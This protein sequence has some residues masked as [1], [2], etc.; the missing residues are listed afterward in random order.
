MFFFAHLFYKLTNHNFPFLGS[1]PPSKNRCQCGTTHACGTSPPCPN[2]VWGV[3][4]RLSRSGRGTRRHMEGDT[5]QVSTSNPSWCHV[6]DT[7][8]CPPPTRNINPAPCNHTT[9]SSLMRNCSWGGSQGQWHPY[10]PQLQEQQ[11]MPAPAT[12]VPLTPPASWATARGWIANDNNAQRH[13][14]QGTWH[15]P[16]TYRWLL[17]GWIMGA[18]RLQCQNAWRWGGWDGTPAPATHH[19][20]PLLA[21]GDRVLMAQSPPPRWQ[22]APSTHSDAHE[23]PLI[24]LCVLMRTTGVVRRG[25]ETM[26]G[27]MGTTRHNCFSFVVIFVSIK[28]I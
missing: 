22:Q 15:P 26:M 8:G 25:M 14:Q 1:I 5:H 7:P 12:M 24:G 9:W 19:C 3:S 17:V 28:N 4:V 20:E 6:T 18:A 13:P 16:H 23:P 27:G 2:G 11:G 21:G 10:P